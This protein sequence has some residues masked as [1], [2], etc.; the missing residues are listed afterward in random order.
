MMLPRLDRVLRQLQPLPVTARNTF[1]GRGVYLEGTYF[2]FISDGV[3]YFRTDDESRS[4]Y[5]ER[6][7]GE[8]QPKYRPRGPKTADRNF[9]VPDEILVNAA[10]LRE[11]AVRAAAARR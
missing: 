6:G 5:L 9:R 1:G 2:G 11:W 7:M 8:L 4:A 10:M 3:L